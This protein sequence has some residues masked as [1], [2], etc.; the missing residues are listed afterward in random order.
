M[1]LHLSVPAYRLSDSG[2]QS[3]NSGMNGDDD[4]GDNYG[5]CLSLEELQSVS[6]YTPERP[7][8]LWEGTEPT[9]SS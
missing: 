2:P 4:G 8:F 1:S 9:A 3:P 5:D 6:A 7:L